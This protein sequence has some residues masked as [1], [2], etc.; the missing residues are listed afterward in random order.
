MSEPTHPLDAFLLQA[1][2]TCGRIEPPSIEYMLAV[3]LIATE[4]RLAAL[5]AELQERKG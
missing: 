5:E 3:R 4:R 2:M 1:L